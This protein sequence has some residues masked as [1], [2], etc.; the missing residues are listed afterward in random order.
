[1]ISTF[2]SSAEAAGDYKLPPPRR[3]GDFQ[4]ALLGMAGHDLRQPLQIIRGTYELLG[5]RMRSKS[6]QAWL[7]RAE[8]AIVRLTE[9]LD[10]LV[11]AL[12]LYEQ[13]KSIDLS[14][15]ALGPLLRRLGR[16]HEDAALDKSVD[17]RVSAS[18]ASV[19]SNPVLLAGI[20]RNL[21]GNAI[22]YTEPG[23]R[24]VIGCRR[25]G[26][27]IRIDVCDTGIGIAPEQLPKIFD[28]FK[29]LDSTR[30]DGLGI[31]L[32]VV[33]R[34]VELLEHRIEVNSAVSK[35]SRFSVFASRAPTNT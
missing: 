12:A 19:M 13:T 26:S 1:M 25:V 18:K 23:G 21:V 6:D 35:G 33:Q 34:A 30:S 31:G 32:F 15:V 29:R 14:V 3:A 27:D 5:T 7:A 20:L 10:R 9:Q 17:L 22:K 11:D 28:A 4:A 16:E 2:Q 24:V 8:R